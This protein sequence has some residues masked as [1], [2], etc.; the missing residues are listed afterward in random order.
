MS[1]ISL[2]NKIYKSRGVILDQLERRGYDIS[3]YENFSLNEIHVLNQNN[4]LDMYLSTDEDDPSKKKRC[5]VKYQL[6]G[7]L[8]KSL[9]ADYTEDLYNIENMLDE[10]DQLI[11]ILKDKVNTTVRNIISNIYLKEKH[12]ISVYNMNRFLF[13]ILDHAM[14]PMHV[15]LS[16]E[17]KVKLENEYNIMSQNQWPEISRFDPVAIAI[18]LRPEQLCKIYRKSPNASISLYYRLCL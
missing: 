9:I 2:N 1:N 7:K 15:P 10:K 8:T 6:S 4:Q 18:G 13:N 17:E 3:E 12:F 16:L 11:I 5:Y 14:I